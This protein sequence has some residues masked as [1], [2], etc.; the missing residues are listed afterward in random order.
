MAFDSYINEGVIHVGPR[1]A[2]MPIAR[3]ILFSVEAK[4]LSHRSMNGIKRLMTFA[5]RVFVP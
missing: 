4:V 2:C 3:T 1:L 5:L